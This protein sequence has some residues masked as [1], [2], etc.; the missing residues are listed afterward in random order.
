VHNSLNQLVFQGP[1]LSLVAN[2][3][4]A[5][6]ATFT[7]G[8]AAGAALEP[9]LAELSLVQTGCMKATKL[10]KSVRVTALWTQDSASA[11]SVPPH[12]FYLGTYRSGVPVEYADAV[13][14]YDGATDAG[15]GTRTLNTLAPIELTHT[16]TP[17]ESSDEG[18]F[19]RVYLMG[20]GETATTVH[21]ESIIWKQ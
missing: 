13:L 21:V 16:F 2:F 6:S 1:T 18:M 10:A 12:G 14:Q 5:S 7:P 15:T 4:N 11:P 17:E 3:S 20:S 9:W 8:P 19:L